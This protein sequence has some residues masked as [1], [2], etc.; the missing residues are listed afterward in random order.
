[1][2]ELIQPQHPGKVIREKILPALGI[3]V[4][5]A[6]MQLGVTRA[7]LSRVL[8]G[9]AGISPEMAL[10]LEKWLE[11]VY[12]NQADLWVTEQALY[13]LW[14]VRKKFKARV[15]VFNGLKWAA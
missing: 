14:L 12:D 8:N 6:A 10:R 2:T 9:K 15:K 7:A 1:M 5:E 11:R 13:D 3:T 4:K